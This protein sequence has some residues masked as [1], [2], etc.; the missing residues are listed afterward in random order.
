[1]SEH[2]ATIRPPLRRHTVGVGVLLAVVIGAF[3][4]GLVM[5]AFGAATRDSGPPADPGEAALSQLSRIDQAL[6]ADDAKSAREML[7]QLVVPAG[8][9]WAAARALREVAATAAETRAAERA[10]ARALALRLDGRLHALAGVEAAVLDLGAV[11]GGAADL[12]ALAYAGVRGVELRASQDGGG[13]WSPPPEALHGQSWRMVHHAL[14]PLLLVL[15]LDQGGGPLAWS[16]R[17]GRSFSA[18]R[19]PERSVAGELDGRWAVGGDS[20]LVV[21]AQGTGNALCLRSTDAG[22]SWQAGAPQ[23]SLLL[24]APTAG[25]TLVIARGPGGVVRLSSDGGATYHDGEQELAAL[26]PPGSN[27]RLFAIGGGCLVVGADGGR[28]LDA[29]GRLLAQAV[30][31]PGK[32]G[33][34]ALIAHTQHAQRWYALQD[35][36]LWRSDDGGGHWRR[37]YGRLGELHGSCLEFASGARPQL[38][39]GGDALYRLD[40]EDEPLLFHDLQ[41]R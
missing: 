24:I 2:P 25:G 29:N 34:Q 13:H 18:L 4:W 31:L 28:G 35:H 9:A 3:G 12:L 20:A 30:M 32:A 19:L 8:P 6:G 10:A 37:G 36:A 11:P 14:S 1:M 22:A 41:A 27:P 17:D 16:T 40:D 23:A 38:L 15:A 26:I 39:I 7:A 33:V 21:G 5:F